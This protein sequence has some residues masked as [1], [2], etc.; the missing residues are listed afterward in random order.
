MKA[1]QVREQGGP[2]VLG[3]DE[4]YIP[5]PGAGQAQVKLASIGVN[6]RDIYQRSGVYKMDLPYIPGTERSGLVTQ[7]GNGVDEVQVGDRIV[8]SGALG[9]YAEYANVPVRRM[10]K[11]PDSVDFSLAAAVMGQGMTAHYLAHSAYPLKPSDTCLVH[12]AAGGV[13][14]LLTQVAKLLGAR[15]IG[16]VSTQEKAKAARSAGC[17]HVILYTEQDFETEVCRFTE[18][19]GV[20]VVY[21]SVGKT[22]FDKGINCLAPRGYMIL[23]GQSSGMVSPIDPQTLNQ[24][25]SLFLT[26]PSGIHY[27]ATRDELV[28]RATDIFGWAASGEL[29]VH[30]D[31]HLPLHQAA[32]AHRR[33]EERRNIGKV[34]LR[35]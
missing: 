17:D 3:L 29:K 35:P 2:E 13:G 22:T 28:W 6:F 19:R 30:I 26:R 9:S 10:I 4:I 33:L 15:V 12:A 18:G 20:Q 24:H 31:A 23:Y 5:P 11:L 1:I 16:T 14:L 25:G 34:L 21:D 8:Y 32:Q 7:V 27:T